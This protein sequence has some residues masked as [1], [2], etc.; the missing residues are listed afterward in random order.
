MADF[1]EQWKGGG[2]VRRERSLKEIFPYLPKPERR[3]KK[4]TETQQKAL[5]MLQMGPL[6]FRSR[7][8]VVT[9]AVLAPSMG[10]FKAL[11]SKKRATMHWVDPQTCEFRMRRPS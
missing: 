7:N 9:C 10:T 2:R 4:L 6:Q 1:S 5:E 8:G 3:P 11:V